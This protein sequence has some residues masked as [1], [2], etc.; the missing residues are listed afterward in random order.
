MKK[1]MGYF[2]GKGNCYRRIIDAMPK[3]EIYIE[4][5][6]GGGAVMRHKRRCRVQIGIDRDP[7]VLAAGSD[8][9]SF[10]ELVCNDA[11]AF[12]ETYKFKGRELVYVDPPYPNELRTP[13]NRY[14]YDYRDE[15][16]ARLI[17]ALINLPCFV[18]ISG[19]PSQTYLE[20]LTDWRRIEFTAGSR[21]G[22]RIEYLWMNFPEII[23]RHDLRYL[24]NDFRER[25]KIKRRM[26]TL[27]RRVDEMSSEERIF[28]AEWF[29]SQ[30]PRDFEI[31]S[32]ATSC[33]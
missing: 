11:V 5:H 16:H 33:V 3:H 24:G 23:P 14:Q 6:I 12:L 8:L 30:H 4:T 29:A 9:Q 22:R 32:G 26:K 15:D 28:F 18:M 17:D 2:G 20:K 7:D 25:E 31:G 19:G 10:C 13:S 21:S 1:F 27:T